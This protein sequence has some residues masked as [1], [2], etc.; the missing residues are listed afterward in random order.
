MEQKIRHLQ[1]EL[2]EYRGHSDGIEFAATFHGKQPVWVKEK[3][4]GPM[5]ELFKTMIERRAFNPV[6]MILQ[7]SIGT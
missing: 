6:D 2:A 7:V 5:D 1:I 4:F 3:T